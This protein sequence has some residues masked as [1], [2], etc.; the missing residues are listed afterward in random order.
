MLR[1]RSPEIDCSCH[2]T[3]ILWQSLHPHTT[4]IN[5]QHAVHVFVSPFLIGIFPETILTALPEFICAIAKPSSRACLWKIICNVIV[6]FYSCPFSL[7]SIHYD[8]SSSVPGTTSCWSWWYRIGHGFL[9]LHLC[10]NIATIWQLFSFCF[11]IHFGNQPKNWAEEK[12]TPWGLH[13][14]GADM[15]TM[16][17]RFDAVSPDDFQDDDDQTHHVS[18]VWLTGGQGVASWSISY[19]DP[20]IERM[21]G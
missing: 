1:G 7:Q 6:V 16:H 4:P 20:E 11:G 15:D 8:T 18:E 17:I 13:W 5:F 19:V 9:A 10:K 14:F 3:S 21:C 12:N 2:H